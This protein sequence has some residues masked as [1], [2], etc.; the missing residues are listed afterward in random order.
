MNYYLVLSLV[1]GPGVH[2]GCFCITIDQ[3]LPVEL[4]GFDAIAGDNEITLAWSTASETDNDYF[5]IK[6]NGE[7]MVHVDASNNAT[8]SDYVWTDTDVSNGITYEYELVNVDMDG[9]QRVIATESATPSHTF[10]NITEYSLAQ[11][12]P[13]PF[14][15]ST[16]I[17]FSLKEAGLVNISVYDVT[18]RLVATLVDG[19]REAGSHSVEFNAAGLPSGI[20]MYRMEAGEFSSVQKMVLMK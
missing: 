15:P 18:G 3:V 20:Y 5:S 6:R 10:A 7:E 19:V 11:N 13:N 17:A 8:G 16:S 2:S 1:P 12:Y 4:V 9:S 14:N